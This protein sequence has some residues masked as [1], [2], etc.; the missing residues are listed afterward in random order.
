LSVRLVEAGVLRPTDST[1]Y[2]SPVPGREIE[3]LYLAPEGGAVAAG[4][5]VVR[6]D[7]AEID[8]EIS[9]TRQAVRQAQADIQAAEADREEALAALDS[10]A[11][12]EKSLE[13]DEAQ[14][15]EKLAERKVARLR[16]EHEGLQQ[17][18]ANGYVTRDELDKLGAELE[19]AQVAL[20]LARRKLALLL[21]KSRPREERRAKVQLAQREAQLGQHRERLT[22]ATQNLALLEQLREGCTVRARGPGLV[23][24]EDSLSASPR[25]KVQVGD[26]VTSS[27]GLVTVSGTSTITVLATVR[28]TDVHLVKPG[29]RATITVDAFPGLVL[30]GSVTRV[31]MVARALQDGPF[32]GKRYDLVVAVDGARPQLRPEMTARVDLLID[33]RMNVLQV[34][35]TAVAVFDGRPTV[36]VSRGGS[37]QEMPVELGW[38]DSLRVEIRRGL[39]EGDWVALDPNLLRQTGLSPSAEAARAGLH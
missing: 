25:R 6:L 18:L 11:T 17:L 39:V 7:T 35:V 38:R 32:D 14:W 20:D 1:T 2:R 26:R 31:G 5:V 9:R 4:D 30:T 37:L 15:A 13:V 27:Q 34:P 29:Q 33:Q 8:G 22:E 24:Y 36:L 3:V 28:E 19:E 16:E 21:E 23:V 12:G 10:L